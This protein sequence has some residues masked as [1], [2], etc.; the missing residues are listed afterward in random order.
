MKDCALERIRTY[1]N[2][3]R[4]KGEISA[5]SYAAEKHDMVPTVPLPHIYVSC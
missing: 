4:N 1:T 3:F 5:L 2:I